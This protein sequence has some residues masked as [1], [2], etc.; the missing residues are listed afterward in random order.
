MYKKKIASLLVTTFIALSSNAL[1]S[2][3]QLQKSF[4]PQQ[5]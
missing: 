2:E 1:A 4:M 5:E 3:Q